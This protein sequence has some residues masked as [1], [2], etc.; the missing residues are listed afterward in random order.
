MTVFFFFFYH[1]RIHDCST[2]PSL[3]VHGVHVGTELL[4]VLR[5][6]P[7]L[8]LVP[9]LAEHV[10]GHVRGDDAGLLLA[11]DLMPPGPHDL[12]VL[13]PRDP[14][15]LVSEEA[16]E[17][18]GCDATPNVTGEELWVP[19]ALMAPHDAGAQMRV[20]PGVARREA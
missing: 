8:G 1:P 14:V 20:A 11:H 3:R 13:R 9:I 6:P 18:D 15:L 12:R 2:E 17:L 19:Q 16:G 5:S 7:L 4:L 10:A